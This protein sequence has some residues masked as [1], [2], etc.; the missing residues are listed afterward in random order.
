MHHSHL[1]NEYSTETTGCRYFVNCA[2]DIIYGE[3]QQCAAN[4]LFDIATNGCN[5]DSMVDCP[6]MS[7]TKRPTKSPTREP[8][9]RPTRRPSPGVSL[10]CSGQWSC[11]VASWTRGCYGCLHH[12]SLIFNCL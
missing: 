6:T 2:N 11:L 7:P 9:K 5:W 4:T 12:I 1:F 3:V 10:I 8:T